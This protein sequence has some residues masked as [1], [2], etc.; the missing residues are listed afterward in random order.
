MKT[1]TK[2]HSVT[3][4]KKYKLKISITHHFDPVVPAKGK[5]L[6]VNVSV[7]IL[8]EHLEDVSCALLGQRIDVP[9]VVAEQRLANQAE[10]GEVQFAVPAM[11]KV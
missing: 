5:F 8:V 3:I 4:R 7:S 2:Q 1:M 9:L 6:L 11:A 10:L